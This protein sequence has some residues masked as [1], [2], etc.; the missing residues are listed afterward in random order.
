M[1][2]YT[3]DTHPQRYADFILHYLNET[4]VLNRSDWCGCIGGVWTAVH[5]AFHTTKPATFPIAVFHTD[6]GDMV[7]VHDRPRPLCQVDDWSVAFWKL[8]AGSRV[9]T[10]PDDRAVHWVTHKDLWFSVWTQRAQ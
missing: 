4:A 6:D 3:E 5:A 2:R 10:D 8:P 1:S 9:N 7:L